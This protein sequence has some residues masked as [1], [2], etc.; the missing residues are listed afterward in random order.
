MNEDKDSKHKAS[1]AHLGDGHSFIRYKLKTPLSELTLDSLKSFEKAF[2]DRS[3]QRHHQT[4]CSLPDSALP[5]A[6]V[7]IDREYSMHREKNTAL[8]QELGKLEAVKGKVSFHVLPCLEGVK[9]NKEYHQG[10]FVFLEKK[11]YVEEEDDDEEDKS[12]E[13]QPQQALV[14]IEALPDGRYDTFHLAQ[15]LGLRVRELN[16]INFDL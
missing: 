16:F 10:G 12:H 11:D 14:E 15:I 9:G 4:R 3:L 8:M 5:L 2:L 7:Y 13:Q 6:L 1:H